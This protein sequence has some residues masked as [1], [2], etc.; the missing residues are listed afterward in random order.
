MKRA[1]K[2]FSALMVIIIVFLMCVCPTITVS[3]AKTNK[4]A[5]FIKYRG[6]DLKNTYAKLSK[7]EEVNVLYYGGSVTNGSGASNA[8]K[9][10]WRALVGNWLTENFPKA[11]VNNINV[12]YGG[13]GSYFGAYRLN[14]DVISKKPDL[15][16]IEFSINDHYDNQVRKLSKEKASM[17]Y[18]TIVRNIWK[19]LPECDIITVLT[20]EKMYI[21]TNRAGNLHT[22]AQ[23]HEDISIAYKIPSLHIGRALVNELS[24]SNTTGDWDKYMTDIV[25]PTDAGYKIYYNVV[26]EYLSNCLKNS[27]YDGK[28]TKHTLVRQVNDYLL[29]GNIKYIDVTQELIDKS[30]DLG[31][32]NFHYSNKKI[33]RRNFEGGAEATN[34]INSKF[35]IEF[36]G[37][38][39]ALLQSSNTVES[40][41]V[42]VDGK[43]SFVDC[44]GIYP[45]VLV[46]GLKSGKHTVIV[47][48]VYD[49]GASS[50]DFF[51]MGFFARDENK[52]SAKYDHKEHIFKKYVSNKDATCK[53]DGTKTAKCSVSGCDMINTVTDKGTKLPH[54]YKIEVTKKATDTKDGEGEKICTLCGRFEGTVVIPKG[55]T[56]SDVLSSQNS[57]SNLT[58]STE[59]EINTNSPNTSSDAT[60]SDA[61][62]SQSAVGN[63]SGKKG[64]DTTVLV[65][66]LVVILVLLAAGIV[67]LVIIIIKRRK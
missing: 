4:Y 26:K 50:G 10:S 59:S 54:K 32:K 57:T 46:K 60:L 33:L 43:T 27:N 17:Q 12:S 53:K 47:Q 39:L 16:F 38:E 1:S 18:E 36:T 62:S 49:G 42:N 41:Q 23:A 40:F 15:I 9:Y 5:D 25:H 37:T 14:E 11:K 3:A 56:T 65:I 6:Q 67:I 45:E 7:G 55:K 20:T 51:I 66:I 61:S 19:E 30:S 2:I 35:V 34:G 52:A 28:V 24:L 8:E 44:V 31:G 63:T 22:H 64:A 29:D 48:P 21:N 58:Q 13:T